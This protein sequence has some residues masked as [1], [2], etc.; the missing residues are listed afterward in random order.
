MDAGLMFPWLCFSAVRLNDS[1]GYWQMPQGGI[2][3][4]EDTWAAALRE[5]HEE[6]GVKDV[7]LLAEVILSTFRLFPMT[8]D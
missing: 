5:L 2:D 7:Q 4:G 6:T 3:A 1:K 8:S